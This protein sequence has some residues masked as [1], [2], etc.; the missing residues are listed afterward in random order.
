MDD[1]KISIVVESTSLSK[2]LGIIQ[3]LLGFARNREGISCNEDGPK[4]LKII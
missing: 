3:Q 4:I 1:V 2:Q